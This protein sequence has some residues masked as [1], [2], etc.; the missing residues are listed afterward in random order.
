MSISGNPA[1]QQTQ[2]ATTTSP[3]QAVAAA[4]CDAG[5]LGIA[6]NVLTS[7]DDELLANILSVVAT[8]RSSASLSC[9]QHA[10]APAS[11]LDSHHGIMTQARHSSPSPMQQTQAGV[12]FN[13]NNNDA[14]VGLSSSSQVAEGFPATN[15]TNSNPGLPAELE[16]LFEPEE[17]REIMQGLQGVLAQ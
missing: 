14:N 11:L 13:N 15:R 9:E 8:A 7:A 1:Q 5:T 6:L 2:C 17:L 10:A 12:S 16:A 3:R 4:S